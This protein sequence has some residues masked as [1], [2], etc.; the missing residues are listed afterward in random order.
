MSPWLGLDAE[1]STSS[2]WEGF[3]GKEHQA[4]ARGRTF[5]YRRCRTELMAPSLSLAASPSQQL[6][7]EAMRHDGDPGKVVVTVSDRGQG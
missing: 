2:S 7:M 5:G 1:G 6:H 3:S 4:P